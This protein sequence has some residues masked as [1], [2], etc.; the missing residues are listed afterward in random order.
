MHG[1]CRAGGPRGERRGAEDS[2]MGRNQALHNNQEL[3]SADLSRKRTGWIFPEG[4]IGPQL[5]L[6]PCVCLSRQAVA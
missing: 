5:L 2:S 4:P 6:T 3:F 1:L